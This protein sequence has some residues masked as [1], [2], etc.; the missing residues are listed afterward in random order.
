MFDIVDDDRL[1][2]SIGVDTELKLPD[3]DLSVGHPR[4]W[5]DV[6]V[7]LPPLVADNVIEF[8]DGIRT[9]LEAHPVRLDVLFG[10]QA[11]GTSDSHSDVDMAVAFD[12][13]L[14]DD[15]R[16]RA[17]IDLVVELTRALGTDDVNIVDLDAVRAEVGA[18]ALEDGLAL[19][20]DPEEVERRHAEFEERT[21]ERTHDERIRRFDE[22][23]GGKDLAVPGVGAVVTV[24]QG[25]PK[26]IQW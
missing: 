17:R 5:L 23:L 11:R 7:W 8:R 12:A 9:V 20:G 3:A 22:L 1:G 2:L 10:S 6:L 24:T 25:V 18:K 15:Q 13:S 14:S 4:E 26:T 21:T 19:V 16:S